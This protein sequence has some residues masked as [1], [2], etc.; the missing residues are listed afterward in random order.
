MT[1]L[2]QPAFTHNYEISWR[3]W[4]ADASYCSLRCW[5]ICRCLLNAMIQKS[6]IDITKLTKY[7]RHEFA[8]VMINPCPTFVHAT[9]TTAKNFSKKYNFWLRWNRSRR[10]KCEILS[11]LCA[12]GLHV[13]VP[14][15]VIQTIGNM[16]E[17]CVATHRAISHLSCSFRIQAL[18][19]HLRA[20]D[21]VPASASLMI[22][23]ND[24]LRFFFSRVS[25]RARARAI[26]V[27]T[28]KFTWNRNNANNMYRVSMTVLWEIRDRKRNLSTV[29]A[30][31]WSVRVSDGERDGYRARAHAKIQL[32][33]SSSVFRLI[34]RYFRCVM[35][36]IVVFPWHWQSSGDH[37]MREE[38]NIK[39]KCI[40]YTVMS[41]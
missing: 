37:E 19:F 4:Q 13:H 39:N 11:I 35:Q 26:S 8:A 23:C 17:N 1:I 6:P 25:E 30:W 14:P 22:W 29:E 20:N 9:T 41:D 36:T 15:C 10:R 38:K 18:F 7:F 2:L 33:F 27:S 21:C 32:L 40:Y 34:F 12:S 31:R 5:S 16:N 28:S 24:T 3:I